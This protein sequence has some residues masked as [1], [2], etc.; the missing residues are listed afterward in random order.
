MGEVMVFLVNLVMKI[1]AFFVVNNMSPIYRR[2]WWQ[3]RAP[4]NHAFWI[5]STFYDVFDFISNKQNE[6]F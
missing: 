2:K 3:I 1:S 4:V 6:A 5:K